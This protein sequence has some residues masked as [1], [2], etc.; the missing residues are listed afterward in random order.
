MWYSC[1]MTPMSFRGYLKVKQAIFKAI[2]HS[3]YVSGFSCTPA[4][5]I[6]VVSVVLS[7]YKIVPLFYS[8]KRLLI[9]SQK[10]IC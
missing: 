5:S 6:S 9:F 4:G 7:G 1:K 2:N 3:M 8:F 10:Q